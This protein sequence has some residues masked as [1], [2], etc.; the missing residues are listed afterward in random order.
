MPWQPSDGGPS[1]AEAVKV[2]DMMLLVDTM[3]ENAETDEKVEHCITFLV[4]NTLHGALMVV[5]SRSQM[6]QV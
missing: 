1:A 4:Q 3:L 2:E 5:G 6:L